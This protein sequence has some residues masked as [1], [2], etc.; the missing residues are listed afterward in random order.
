MVSN[1]VYFGEPPLIRIR[2]VSDRTTILN[3]SENCGRNKITFCIILIKSL[4]AQKRIIKLH[5]I[6]TTRREPYL[7]IILGQVKT[8]TDWCNRSSKLVTVL[9]IKISDTISRQQK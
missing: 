5:L 8:V 4:T 7:Q 1:Q 3:H 9:T 2:V 6:I